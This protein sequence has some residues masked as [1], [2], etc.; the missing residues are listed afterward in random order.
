MVV[1]GCYVSVHIWDD[2]AFKCLAMLY[3]SGYMPRSN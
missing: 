2:I 3:A 1:A